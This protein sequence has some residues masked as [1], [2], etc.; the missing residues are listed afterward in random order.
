MAN[1]PPR[2]K[3]EL[4]SFLGKVNFLRRFI[5]NLAGKIRPLTPLLKLKDSE[6]FVW[7]AEHQAAL[8]DIKKYLSQ[9]P[10]LMPP[11][12]GKPLRLY[13]SASEGS[14]GCLLAQNNESGREQAVYYLSRTLNTAELNYSPIE[15]LCLALYFAATKL[16]HYMLPSVVQIISKTDL[17]KYMLTRPIIRGRIGKWTM[18]LSEF[19][20]Q[21]M[22]QKSVKGQAL[23]DFLAHH[24]AQG[25]DGELEVEIGMARMEKNYWTMYFDGSCIEARS[26]AGVVIESPQGQR[27]QFAFQL[28]FKCTNNQAEYEALIIGLEILKE[29]KATRV[30]VYSDSQLVIN[31]LIGEYQCTSENLTMYYVTALNTADDFSRI[32]FVHVPRAENHE[33]NEMAQVASGVN[34]P[35][36]D[37]DRVIRIERR[38]LPAL[39]ERRMAAQVS[40]AEIADEVNMAEA[41]WRYPIV[42]YLRDPSGS[43]ERTTRFRARCYLIYQNELYRK[44]SNG[45]LLLCPSAEDIKVIMTESHEGICGAHQSGVKMRWLVRRHGYYWPTILKDCIEYMRGCIKC[46]IYGPIQRVPAEAHHPV[47]KPWPFRGWAVDIIGKI[48]PAASNQ[49]AWILV[50]TDYFTKWVEAESY[51]SISS[52]Q[53][54]KF[55]ENHIVH[56]FGIPETIT[57]D[58]GPVFAS[59]ETREYTEKMGIKLVH[60]T[61]YYPQSNR[62]AEASNKVI[63]GILEKMF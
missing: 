36:T 18:A 34:I 57:A 16:R 17:I 4:Q 60:S 14:I 50:A 26:G 51:R 24:S 40:S 5:S 42:K 6:Q 7:G 61:P 19:T 47:T 3:K 43:H 23:A 12:R 21:Y 58:N 25:Q 62:Q 45:L 54:V 52:A 35:D 20:F 1:P 56:R 48:H 22:G 46:Q 10:V 30:L 27:W 9:P 59:A 28:N 13:I 37:H 32:T 53:V 8:D 29:M 49:H 63:K 31:Q 11:K 44:G 39:A 2:T 55:F 33:A 15:K 38:T 41:D